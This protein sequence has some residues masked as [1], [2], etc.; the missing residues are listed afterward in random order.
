MAPDDPDPAPSTSSPVV[1]EPEGP[2]SRRFGDIYFSREDGL[3]ESRAVFVAGC[4]LPEAWR[5]RSRFCVAEL[6]FGTGLNIAALLHAWRATAPPDAQLHIF[7][8]ENDLITAAEAERA[9]SAWP[10]LSET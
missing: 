3:A 4:G 2:R 5:S 7:T 1:W 9:L 8:V 6:G 10:D